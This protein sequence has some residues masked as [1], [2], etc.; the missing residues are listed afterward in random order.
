MS[1]ELA[2]AITI[3][4][5]TYKTVKALS[6]KADNIELKNHILNMNEQ[7]QDFREAAIELREE[8]TR[9][10]EE[11]K[12]L[13]AVSEKKLVYKDGVYYDEFEAAFCPNCYDK[14]KEL[15]RMSTG[16]PLNNLLICKNCKYEVTK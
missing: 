1:I 13:T 16:Y 7:I 11:I 4:T 14:K 8:N 6:E 10:K 15:I 12:R 2:T 9:L 3:L 5:T